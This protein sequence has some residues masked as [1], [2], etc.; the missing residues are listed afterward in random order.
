MSPD[1]RQSPGLN[2]IPSNTAGQ[3]GSAAHT[4]VTLDDDNPAAPLSPSK[5]RQ[6]VQSFD[7]TDA[8]R[9]VD[10][11]AVGEERTLLRDLAQC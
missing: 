4:V 3:W 10:A 7:S 8:G 11:L 9:G 1:C 6:H 2:K 5:W